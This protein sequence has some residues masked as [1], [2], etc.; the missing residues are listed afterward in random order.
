MNT[1]NIELSDCRQHCD[2][3]IDQGQQDQRELHDA[4][5]RIQALAA[6]M[7]VDENGEAATLNN[8]LMCN[9]IFIFMI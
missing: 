1:K 4:Q 8:Q 2:G 6:G 7:A 5:K 3:F 9:L